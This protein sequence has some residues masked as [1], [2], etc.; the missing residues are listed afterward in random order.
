[1][2]ATKDLNFETFSQDAHEY[3]N[4]LAQELGHPQ[5]KS[6]VLKIWRAVMH[7]LRDR[8]HL[9]ESLQL[10]DP[11]NAILKGIYVEN[12]KFSEKPPLEY[13]TLEEMK[14]EVKKLQKFYGEDDFP[15]KKPT[16][17]IILI[18]LNSLQK[19]MDKSQLEHIRGQMPKEI[20][21]FLEGKI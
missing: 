1:M 19:F 9:G 4:Y 7:T 20:K 16:E 2:M 6:R 3:M 5:E 10:I 18:T 14:D 21:T 11:L 17:E 8:I 13:D 15:W 12:W